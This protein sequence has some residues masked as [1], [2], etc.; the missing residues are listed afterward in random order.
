MLPYH[1]ELQ[2]FSFLRLP[3]WRWRW[4]GR[5]VARGRHVTHRRD[6]DTTARAVHYLRT[7]AHRGEAT[8]ERRY[9]E[10]AAAQRLHAA[11]GV[12]RLLV[13]ARLLARQGT[14]D[15]ARLTGVPARVVEAYEALF[16]QCRDRLDACDWVTARLIGP[17]AGQ[18]AAPDAESVLKKFAYYGGP[19]VLDAVLPYLVGGRDLFDPP[20]DLATPAGRREQSFRLAVAAALLPNDAAADK[21]LHRIRSILLECERQRIVYGVSGPLL[22]QSLDARLGELPADARIAHADGTVRGV[23][24]PDVMTTGEAA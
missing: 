12:T 13:Q 8:A 23:Q 22:A 17:P 4:A 6:D 1:P 18:A 7:L 21:K 16:F 24:A 20:P 15:V 3:D 2:T 9:P 19:A 14:A 5:L 10:V 11:G